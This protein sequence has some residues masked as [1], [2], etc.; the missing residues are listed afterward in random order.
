[1]QTSPQIQLINYSRENYTELQTDSTEEIVNSLNQNGGLVHWV[2]I[3]TL[4]RHVVKAAEK[5]FKFHQLTTED[6][7]NTNHLPKL[8]VFEDHC[9]LI[10]KIFTYSEGKKRFDYEHVGVLLFEDSLLLLQEYPGDIFDTVRLK[11]KEG[12]GSIRKGKSDYLFYVLI[13]TL[14]DHYLEI[15]EEMRERAERMENS[16][17]EGEDSVTLNEIIKMKR[18]MNRMR[19]FT[20]PLITE[21]KKIKTEPPSFFDKSTLTYMEDV[22]DHLYLLNTNFEYLRER[23]M[24]LIN[25]YHYKLSENTNQVMKVLTVVSTIFIPITFVAGLYGMNFQ[26][27]PELGWKYGY[28]AAMGVMAAIAGGMIYYMR[29][30]GWM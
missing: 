7:L 2:N 1:M 5:I 9:F 27:M 24:D 19:K 13:D 20:F 4:D 26:D 10:M 12:S 6:I 18:Q 14:V 11:I 22:F 25:L 15:M 3:Q 30:K 23:L 17:L 28:P 21:V 16:L 8:D 29:R